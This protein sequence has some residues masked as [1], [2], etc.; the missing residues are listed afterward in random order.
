MGLLDMN[1]RLIILIV[2]RLSLLKV[3]PLMCYA[4][5]MLLSV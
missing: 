2:V 3:N 1:P 4:F 5:S